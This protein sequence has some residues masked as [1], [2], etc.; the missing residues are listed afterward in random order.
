VPLAVAEKPALPIR[1]GKVTLQGGS[2]NFT[3]NFVKPNYSANLRQIGGRINGLS[4]AQGTVATLDLRGSYDRIAPL[5]IKARLNPLTKEPF[6][7]LEADVKGVEMTS[8]SPYSGKY[9]GYS[10]AKGK[11]SLFVKYRI[12]NRQLLAENRVF[13]D[14]LTFGDPVDSPEATKLP[15]TLAVALL[16]NRA[17]EIDIN[18]PVS[19]SLDDPQ[20]S[21]GGLVIKVIVNLLVKAVTSPFA[22]LG[23]LF[24]GGEELSH[25][26]FAVGRATLDTTAQ[27]RLD[28][29][30]AALIDRPALK[31]EIAGSVDTL[32]DREGLKLAMIERKMRRL[33]RDDLTKKGIESGSADEIDI[34]AG[35]RTALLE[36]VYR[37]EKFPKPRNLV[38]LVKSLPAEEMEKLIVTNT[39]ISDDDLR[40]LG[41]RRAARVRDWL[42]EK[43]SA[44]TER[45]FLLPAKL[46]GDEGRGQAS[47]KADAAKGSGVDFSLR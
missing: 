40:E 31:L 29:L 24:S 12:E 23:S 8:F 20:F 25:V 10:I 36:R 3:D 38:G 11:L 2:V 5:S 1:I 26:D 18:L 22:L 46:I 45:I 4:S 47:G 35:E 6:L 15:V 16:K 43:S 33:K 30:A 39:Q 41:D 19:G 32:A 17:G 14:Q 34:T 44:P 42:V 27:Q 28:K 7:D 9:A 37:A 21:V 13:L